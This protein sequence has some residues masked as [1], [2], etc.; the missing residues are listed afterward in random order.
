M[1]E[2]A[3]ESPSTW[4]FIPMLQTSGGVQMAIDAWLFNQCEKGQHPPTLRFYTWYPH[5]LSLGH[6]QRQWPTQW[7]NLTYQGQSLE[8]VRRPTGG[9][10]VL[11]QGDLSYALITSASSGKSWGTYEKICNFLIQGWQTLGI[12]LNYGSAGRGYIH[13]PSC[14]NTATAADLV[15][16]DGSKFIG[17]AQRK[18]RNTI[19]QHGSMILSTDKGLFQEIFEQPA[20][21]NISLCNTQEE[22]GWIAK[23][24][25]TL[26]ETAKQH[27]GI[28][29]VTQPFTDLEWQDI[30][31]LRSLYEVH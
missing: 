28:E 6:L 7:H 22:D 1:R 2:L 18:G 10:A 26:T 16:A 19:L 24:V 8:L 14:F 23:I 13:N 30:L 25:D 4:R 21:W 5:A 27:F 3:I 29:L 12:Q 9:R 31:K 11:H 17:S 20:P 15:T